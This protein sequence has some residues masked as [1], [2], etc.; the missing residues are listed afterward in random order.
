MGAKVQRGTWPEPP[1]FG[2]IA[3]HTS[4]TPYELFHAFNM[5]LGMLVIIP[6]A[7]VGKAL[8]ALPGEVY[9]VGEI[10]SGEK[11]VEIENLY[12]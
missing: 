11:A 4:T 3:Q 5:G 6:A 12:G 7:D 8:A 9:R 10:V 2:L 1:I